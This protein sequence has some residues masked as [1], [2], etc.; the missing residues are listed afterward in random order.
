MNKISLLSGCLRQLSNRVCT[1]SD[2]RLVSC[3]G[4]K[5]HTSIVH[6]ELYKRRMAAGP[7]PERP[8][9]A[10]ANWNYDAEIYAFG[11]RL[12]ENFEDSIIRTAFVHES[13]L[14]EEKKK[15]QELGI[16]EDE[17]PS[18]SFDNSELIASGVTITSNYI[19][20]YL[21]HVFPKLPEFCVQ[22]IHDYLMSED[23][24]AYVSTHIGTKDLVLCSEFPPSKQTL[25][26]T[27]IGIVGALA[28]SQNQARAE[29]FVQDFI[30]TQLHGKELMHLLNITNPMGLLADILQ[31]EKLGEP[32]ARLLWQTGSE[33]VMAAYVVGV[34]SDKELIGES[35]GET[36]QIAEEMA[37]RD[38]L[39]KYFGLTDNRA[40]LKFGKD[41]HQ[42]NIKTPQL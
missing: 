20:A 32:E 25:A 35:A 21:K 13:Y 28:K 11:K 16:E 40:G 9:S 33:T 12:H 22:D 41:G 34:Y 37:A 10:W 3:H 39:R 18:Q 7:E 8:R 4:Y 27:L 19:E 5:R 17:T 38:A 24:L 31:K 14:E 1:P 30:L 6:K 29:I 23:I 36:L 15:Q 26:H 2:V 42:L